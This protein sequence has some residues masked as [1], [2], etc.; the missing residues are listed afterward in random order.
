MADKPRAELEM[1]LQ[2]LKESRD[3]RKD[4]PKTNRKPNADYYSMKSIDKMSEEKLKKVA[5]K[6]SIKYHE[7]G[8]TGISTN[9]TPE[10]MTDMLLAGKSKSELKKDVI[11][12]QRRLK[13]FGIKAK[14]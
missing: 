14:G 9:F 13:K 5:K 12:L 7:S 11:A 3:L 1:E 6:L 2:R 10:E 4:K 8:R